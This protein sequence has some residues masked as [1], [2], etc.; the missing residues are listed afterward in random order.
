MRNNYKEN[1]SKEC[2]NK[3][4]QIA[5]FVIIAIVIVAVVLVVFLFPRL[6]LFV[7]DVNPT[8]FLRSCIKSEV[9]D[10]K[11]VLSRQGGYL[12]PDNYVLY[13]GE[14][15]QYLCYTSQNYEPCLVQQPLLVRH[16]ENEIKS[17]VEPTARKCVQD[18]KEQYERQG[19]SV[20]TTSGEIDVDLIPGSVVVNFLAPMTVSKETT[21]TFQKF[22]VGLDSE[23][24]DLLLNAVSI[25]DFES[26]L[27]DS[28]TTLYIQYYPDLRVD[29]TKREGDT[30]YKLSNVITGDEFTFA[31]R[32]LVWPEGYGFEE[33]I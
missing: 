12:E 22:A 14:K 19:F 3:R 17:Q 11:E 16:V 18:L 2:M 10:V 31:S 27:G 20:Q 4:G 13:N 26:T 28:E 25:I 23:W 1:C 30:I 5:I 29:K 24:Y 6:N 21:Q 15:I 9:E 8:S 33:L 32:S 7:T